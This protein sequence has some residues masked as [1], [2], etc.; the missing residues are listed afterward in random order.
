M[1]GISNFRVN[2]NKDVA[3]EKYVRGVHTN[4]HTVHDIVVRELVRGTCV[5]DQISRLTQSLVSHELAFKPFLFAMMYSRKLIL[6]TLS[7]FFFW[8]RGLT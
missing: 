5:F 8:R 7:N 2:L 6:Q 4:S 3:Y 1:L